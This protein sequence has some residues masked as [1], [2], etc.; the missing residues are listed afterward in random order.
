ME[1][2]RYRPGLLELLDQR[3][4]PAEEHWVGIT[5]VHHAASAITDM[6]VRGAPAIAITAGY[7]MALAVRRGRVDR[8]QAQELL[9]AARPTA[10]NLRW[11]LERLDQV[12][13]ARVEPEA[14]RLHREDLDTNR[15]I[16][17]TG[18]RVLPPGGVLTICNTGALATGGWGTALGVVRSLVCAG[19]AV[20][21]WACE[22]R[23]YLQGAR[24]TAWEC[25]REGIP[26]TLI[27]D[28]MAGALM[29]EGRINSV[30]VGADRVAANGDAA[31]KIGTY[32]L[33]VLAKH[34]GVPFYVA[35]PRSTLDLRCPNGQHIPIEERSPDELTTL[36]G[37]R[38]APEG[39]HVWNPAFDVTPADL[40]TGWITEDGLWTPETR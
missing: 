23:P 20:H 22:T 15:R 37:V 11:I 36:R 9:L 31:N 3:R 33:A 39:I 8:R 16:G 29:A 10:V 17:M 30:V 18:A 40:I 2:I 19:N 26:C 4:L 1:A 6:V 12:P 38:I 5:D 27:A 25:Q 13:D 35:F 32:T 21:V 24:L 7:G 14:I 34:H 28:S